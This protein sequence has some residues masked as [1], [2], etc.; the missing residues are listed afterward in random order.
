VRTQVLQGQAPV[1]GHVRIAAVAA[2]ARGRRRRRRRCAAAPQER[3]QRHE[4]SRRQRER[5]A[6]VCRR[7]QARLPCTQEGN[8][9]L[10][11]RVARGA[12]GVGFGA[13]AARRACLP[14]RASRY[15]RSCRLTAAGCCAHPAPA[16]A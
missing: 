4:R 14:V 5:L 11:R 1:V 8:N 12:G 2:A 6:S 15:A 10:R 13:C 3:N 7:G 16:R 9:G